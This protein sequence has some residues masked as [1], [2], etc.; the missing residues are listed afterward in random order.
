MIKMGESNLKEKVL[1]ELVKRSIE[2]RFDYIEFD[3]N[4]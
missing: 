1:E 3:R 2:A 4:Y